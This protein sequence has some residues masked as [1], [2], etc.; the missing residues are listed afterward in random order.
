MARGRKVVQRLV[1]VESPSP[2]ALT[3]E[4]ILLQLKPDRDITASEFVK[5]AFQFPQIE[6]ILVQKFSV[7]TWNFAEDLGNMG[8]TQETANVE[9]YLKD[10][11]GA[12]RFRLVAIVNGEAIA[13]QL[14]NMD[15]WK[16]SENRE[17]ANTVSTRGPV[18]GAGAKPTGP[19]AT[20]E[21]MAMARERIEIANTT[22]LLAGLSEQKQAVATDASFAPAKMMAEMSLT[23]MQMMKEMVSA[24]RGGPAAPQEDRFMAYLQE[25]V[26]FL[27]DQASKP[28]ASRDPDA[29]SRTITTIDELLGK[30]LNTS[31][32]EMIS[33]TNK[34]EASG[35]AA[36][37]QGIIEGVKPYLG[38][39]I[40]AARASIPATR[41]IGPATVI[42]INRN[43]VDPTGTSPQATEEIDMKANPEVME[44]IN[45]MI[46]ALKN[47]DH[48]TVDAIL[49]NP[50]L[51]GQF[52]IN[53]TTKGTV[54][55]IML[56]V[57]DPRFGAMAVEI[58]AYLDHIKEEIAKAEAEEKDETTE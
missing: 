24:M 26:R 5:R 43:R 20:G 17:S 14:L 1:E 21:L 54:Y 45:L 30:T 9:A 49:T 39:L 8:P 46:E 10:K 25:E 55:A 29:L 19:G 13:S 56:K 11:Y 52:N 57:V 33:G 44:I 7:G 23:M 22:A 15:G 4:R 37:V 34:T 28:V 48:E 32:A 41:A 47:K 35:W 3:V 6:K 18:L 27:R 12:W 36:T 31:L 40:G 50:P 38:D 2:S 51:R 58:Q 42:P 53:P 16:E